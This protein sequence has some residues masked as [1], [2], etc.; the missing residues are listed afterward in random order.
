MNFDN[1]NDYMVRG[2]KGFLYGYAG[3][4]SYFLLIYSTSVVQVLVGLAAGIQVWN[5][6]KNR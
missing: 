3:I 1:L 4:A 5:W 6:Y 2:S